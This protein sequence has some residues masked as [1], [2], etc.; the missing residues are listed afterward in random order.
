[1]RK[2][3]T[4]I[5]MI[6]S[7]QMTKPMSILIFLFLFISSISFGEEKS[8]QDSIYQLNSTWIDHTGKERKLNTFKGKLVLITMGYTSCAHSCPL[9]ISKMKTIE[10]E[11]K[12]KK[13]SN[14]QIVFASFDTKKDRP[15][16]LNKY[17]QKKELDTQIWTMIS[18]SD[19]ANVRELANVLGVNYKDI[20][21]GDFVH[22]NVITALD[23]QGN[24]ISRLGS[25]NED[26][27]LLIKKMEESHG[28]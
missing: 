9:I 7:K 21:D 8:S 2:V 22:S 23:I 3:G 12:L 25:L 11:L 13:I 10:S 16:D 17:I 24:I 1:M 18:T 20:G 14:Y 15:K 5:K 4:K 6:R 28:K 26:T 27:S 19:E